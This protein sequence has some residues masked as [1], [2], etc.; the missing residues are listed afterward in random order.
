MMLL[1]LGEKKKKGGREI[2]V[3]TMKTANTVPFV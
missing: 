1:T 2:E 3:E